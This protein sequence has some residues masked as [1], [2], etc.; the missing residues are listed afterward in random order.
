LKGPRTSRDR[1]RRSQ[2][3][4]W[5]KQTSEGWRRGAL[6][7]SAPR[8]HGY[9]VSNKGYG[10]RGR[11]FLQGSDRGAG[12]YEGATRPLVAAMGFAAARADTA[13]VFEAFIEQDIRGCHIANAVNED[14]DLP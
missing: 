11:L 8:N 12:W 5:P 10:Y 3:L 6:R 14:R 7:L 4:C 13:Q 2:A 1:R 9:R